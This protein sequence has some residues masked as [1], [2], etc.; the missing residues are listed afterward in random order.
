M[1]VSTE[2]QCEKSLC[3]S[4]LPSVK[5]VQ[6]AVL[7]FPATDVM[8][9][10]VH[11]RE[12]ICYQTYSQTTLGQG[13]TSTF[14]FPLQWFGGVACVEYTWVKATQRQYKAEH[15]QFFVEHMGR[16]VR[17]QMVLCD[18]SPCKGHPNYSEGWWRQETATNLSQKVKCVGSLMS[19][20]SKQVQISTH[21]HHRLPYFKSSVSLSSR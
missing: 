11:H 17:T 9:C 6:T 1:I 18:A 12:F 8:I 14:S 19:W 2:Y 16:S 20:W 15:M 10:L 4:L 5:V 7:P 21:Y 3:S 13:M